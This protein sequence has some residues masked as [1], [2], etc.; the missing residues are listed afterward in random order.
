MSIQAANMHP[1]DTTWVFAVP[2]R[3]HN[4][5]VGLATTTCRSQISRLSVMVL[6]TMTPAV[7]ATIKAYNNINSQQE[8]DGEPSLADPVVG[9]PISHGQLIEIS[10][11]LK[12]YMINVENWDND[13]KLKMRL[14]DLLEGCGLYVPP[15]APKPEKVDLPYL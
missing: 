15:P 4:S 12:E 6:L 1:G 11:F 10:Q 14:S 2:A 8:Q 5:T 9:G 7:V 3:H 13:L